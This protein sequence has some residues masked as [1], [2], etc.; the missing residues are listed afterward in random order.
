MATYDVQDDADL[1]TLVR[2]L[3]LYEDTARELPDSKLDPQI[4]VAKMRLANKTDSDSFYT[5]SGL[6]QA[7]VGWTCILAKCAVE[8]Y[9]VSQWDV[10]PA[11]IDVR[12]AG[13]AEQ[14]QFNEWAEMVSEGISESDATENTSITFSGGFIGGN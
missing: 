3:T 12:G 1:K 10:G 6:G 8:N 4:R 9:S 11:N 7:L 13:D 5:D 14:V 2:G